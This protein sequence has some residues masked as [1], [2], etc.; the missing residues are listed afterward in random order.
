MFR[1]LRW[2]LLEDFRGRFKE[3]YFGICIYIYLYIFWTNCAIHHNKYLYNYMIII[4]CTY[5]NIIIY[6]SITWINV[7]IKNNISS[8]CKRNIFLQML[9]PQKTLEE[10]RVKTNSFLPLIGTIYV[11][12][13]S[14][15]ATVCIR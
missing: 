7:K 8:Q 4:I 6:A 10:F 3:N 14:C 9:W 13:I 11:A 1:K 12:E 2:H 15:A 5:M